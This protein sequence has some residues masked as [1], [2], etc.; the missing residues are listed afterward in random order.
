MEALVDRDEVQKA[1]KDFYKN[2]SQKHKNIGVYSYVSVK[3]QDP[4]GLIA[5][6]TAKLWVLTFSLY[7]G[8]VRYFP[9]KTVRSRIPEH[10]ERDFLLETIDKTVKETNSY[11]EGVRVVNLRDKRE[12]II[13]SCFQNPLGY[14]DPSFPVIPSAGIVDFE[15]SIEFVCINR[16]QKI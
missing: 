16:V 14:T 3:G 9:K 12:G 8:W 11:V 4:Q 2:L 1:S 5:L 13:V 10:G 6:Q 7:E 15:S